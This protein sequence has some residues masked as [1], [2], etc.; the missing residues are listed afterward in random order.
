MESA[1]FSWLLVLTYELSVLRK[2]EIGRP[3]NKT[4]AVGGAYAFEISHVETL[5]SF[6]QCVLRRLLNFVVGEI[7]LLV[8]IRKE[9]RFDIEHVVSTAALA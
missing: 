8:R 4:V 9:R 5:Y 7:Y 3:I 6:E 2:P 1:S